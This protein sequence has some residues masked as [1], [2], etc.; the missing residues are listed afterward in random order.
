[1]KKFLL[2]AT[3]FLLVFTLIAVSSFIKNSDAEEDTDTDESFDIPG[4]SQSE[5]Y[6]ISFVQNGVTIHTLLVEEG[7]TFCIP[8]LSV[9]VPDGGDY[10]L[11]SWSG[12]GSDYKVGRYYEAPEGDVVLTP[13]F[14]LNGS[15]DS[16]TGDIEEPHTHVLS[17]VTTT[18]ATCVSTGVKTG[19]CSCGY[20]E[21]ES[22]AIDS[23][24]HRNAELVYRDTE[25]HSVS[26]DDCGAFYY[27]DHYVLSGAS[28]CPCGGPPVG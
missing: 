13:V 23:D 6:T 3:V 5:R 21:T 15:S 16:E 22:I 14:V 10:V 26:C 17:Y 24:N 19:T 28:Y 27:E 11:D 18:Y 1:M 7:D 8:V 2:F 9:D 20:T 25:S 12:G 4:T